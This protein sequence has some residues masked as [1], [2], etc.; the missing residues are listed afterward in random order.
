MKAE[1]EK[2]P[3]TRSSRRESDVKPIPGVKEAEF[4]QLL[5]TDLD[6]ARKVAK[7]A[8]I[9]LQRHLHDNKSAIIY[10]TNEGS[11]GQLFKIPAKAYKLLNN[12]QQSMDQ[13]HQQDPMQTKRQEYRTIKS[14][15][16]SA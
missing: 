7:S 13:M 2:K 9:E 4:D 6:F 1:E 11:I 8:L 10:G 5:R 15:L 16:T 12:L 3:A 14:S